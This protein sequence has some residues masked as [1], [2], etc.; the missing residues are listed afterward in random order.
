M[1]AGSEVCCSIM[2]PTSFSLSVSYFLSSSSSFFFLS[3]SSLLATSSALL[4]VSCSSF[5]F[6]SSSLLS[7]LSTSSASLLASSSLFLAS[8]SSA[9][10]CSA[11]PFPPLVVIF[12]LMQSCFMHFGKLIHPYPN[13]LYIQNAHWL[14]CSVLQLYSKNHSYGS[15]FLQN[16]ISPVPLQTHKPF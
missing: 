10:F 6:S 11:W 13:G 5:F 15:L 1:S 4:A 3:S 12:F 2:D 16:E 14:P 7:Q 8:S 9:F